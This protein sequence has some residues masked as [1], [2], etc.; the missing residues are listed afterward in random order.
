MMP[1]GN[2]VIPYEEYLSDQNDMTEQHIEE[3]VGPVSQ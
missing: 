3:S 1:H 2:A